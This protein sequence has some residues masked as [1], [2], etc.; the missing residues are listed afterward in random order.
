MPALLAGDLNDVPDSRTLQELGKQWTRANAEVLP[1]IPVE[2]PKQQI[3]YVLYRPTDRWR[4]V[5]VQVL[6]E[7]TASDHRPL[8]AVLELRGE[9]KA[10]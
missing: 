3:D 7:A 6:D 9:S 4:L 1:T 5:E 8:L 10:E 2:Q